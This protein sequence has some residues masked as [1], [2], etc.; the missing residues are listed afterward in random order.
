M[1]KN[2]TRRLNRMGRRRFYE[3]L[4]K[5]GVSTAALPFISKDTLGNLT[6]D[7]ENE[8]PRVFSL[9]HTNHQKVAKGEEP[10]D[11][12]P[13]TFTISRDEW[14]RIEGRKSVAHQLK[15]EFSQEPLIRFGVAKSR[16]HGELIVKA[17]YLT[18]KT[19]TGNTRKQDVNRE[20]FKNEIPTRTSTT[21]GRRS[22][23]Q[24]VENILVEAR[25]YIV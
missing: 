8:V 18:V 19:P 22:D 11:R 25:K 5:L 13:V 16:K 14:A 10:P 7:P 15:Q 2:S 12:E 1:K 23:E 21:V 24:K 9:D 3:T 17:E 6:D 20:K 4:S